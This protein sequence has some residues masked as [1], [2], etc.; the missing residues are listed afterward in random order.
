MIILA[1]ITFHM[2]VVAR[3]VVSTCIGLSIANLTYI[4]YPRQEHRL[5]GCADIRSKRPC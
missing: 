3:G 1:R 4:P 5:L 2:C